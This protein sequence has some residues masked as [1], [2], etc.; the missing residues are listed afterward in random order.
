VAL[1]ALENGVQRASHQ[2][3]QLLT[4]AALDHA[5]PRP[6]QP[7]DLVEM[8]REILIELEPL[9]NSR[10][11]VLSLHSP[12]RLV[13][14]LD[15]DALRLVLVNLVRNAIQHGAE[16]GSVEVQLDRQQG[17]VTLRVSDN[18][19][20]ILAHDRARVFDRFYRAEAAQSPG[21]GL[22]LA[23]VLRAAQ[24]LN[25]SVELANGQQGPGVSLV[26]RWAAAPRG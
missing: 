12:D 6:A 14:P 20:G 7:V 26:V 10:G 21:S 11:A 15:A 1:Q 9:A 16:G 22:G 17:V 13:D 25:A 4:L 18:G 24:R 8:I 2:V 5:S 23:I 19:P 3:N